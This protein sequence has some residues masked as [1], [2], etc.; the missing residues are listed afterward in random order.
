VWTRLGMVPPK[1]SGVIGLMIVKALRAEAIVETG[2]TVRSAY[3]T[4][5]ISIYR[6]AQP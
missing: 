2:Q 6:K 3:H 1:K 4:Q 5:E